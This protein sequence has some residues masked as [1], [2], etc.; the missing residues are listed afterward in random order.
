MPNQPPGGF[1]LDPRLAAPGPGV[2]LPV[3]GPGVP[4]LVQGAGAGPLANGNRII[5]HG[6]SAVYPFAGP[7]RPPYHGYS[8]VPLAQ[9]GPH[10]APYYACRGGCGNQT[11]SPMV[12][13]CYD[14][15]PHVTGLSI[16]DF[17]TYGNFTN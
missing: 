3:H 2:P 16:E 1:A 15:I 4:A 10:Q 9:A 13:Y 12:P 14:C 6:F 17:L 8:P 5:P 11:Q 7:L